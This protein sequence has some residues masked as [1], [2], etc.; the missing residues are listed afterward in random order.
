MITDL[1]TTKEDQLWDWCKSKKLFTSDEV[2]VYG[3]SH[4]YKSAERRV[5]EWAQD[6]KLRRLDA[7][8][9]KERGLKKRETWYE[10]V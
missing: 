1:F 7:L 3:Y 5:G 9:I 2:Y 6:G 8:E 10:V 4:Y